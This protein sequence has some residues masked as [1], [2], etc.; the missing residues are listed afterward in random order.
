MEMTIYGLMQIRFCC[1]SA[2]PKIRFVQQF[3]VE[4]SCIEFQQNTQDGLWATWASW[5]NMSENQNCITS[6]V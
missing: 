5:I 1:E 2:C 6:L 4:A 3:L